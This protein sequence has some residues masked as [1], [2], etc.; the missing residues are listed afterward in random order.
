MHHLQIVF[1]FARVCSFIA[2]NNL[3]YI[4]LTM[5]NLQYTFNYA[6]ILYI[7]QQCNGSD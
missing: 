6:Y 1:Y 2:M 7:Y 5:H 4:H 3:Q